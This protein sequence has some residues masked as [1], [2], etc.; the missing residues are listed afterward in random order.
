MP[1]PRHAHNGLY[2]SIPI[3]FCAVCSYL[4]IGLEGADHLEVLVMGY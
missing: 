4:L 2:E 1:G 3:V